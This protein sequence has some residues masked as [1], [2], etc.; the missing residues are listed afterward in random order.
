[1]KVGKLDA[2]DPSGGAGQH[3]VEEVVPLPI[4]EL[5]FVLSLL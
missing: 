2:G 1:M 5:K 4:A 3:Q